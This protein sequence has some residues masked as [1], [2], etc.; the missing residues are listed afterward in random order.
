MRLDKSSNIRL[1]M[2]CPGLSRVVPDFPTLLRLDAV[3]SGLREIH[4][5]PANIGYQVVS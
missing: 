4:L 1:D 5:E 3:A 2:D